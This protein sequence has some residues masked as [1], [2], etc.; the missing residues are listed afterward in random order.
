MVKP[1]IETRLQDVQ[2]VLKVHIN[3]NTVQFTSSVKLTGAFSEQPRVKGVMKGA[4][5]FTLVKDG[6]EEKRKE[7]Q[8]NRMI[9]SGCSKG[10]EITENGGKLTLGSD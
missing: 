2:I 6:S 7:R 8:E 9:T 1:K 4:T 10:N 3:S 5:E